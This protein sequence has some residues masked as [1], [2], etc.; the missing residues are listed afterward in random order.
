MN[1]LATQQPSLPQVGGD[2]SPKTFP[3][4]IK[5]AEYFS[6]SANHLPWSTVAF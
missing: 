6:Q 2:F 3:E 5:F 1:E 4:V